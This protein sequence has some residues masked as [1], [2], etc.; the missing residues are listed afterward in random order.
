MLL[1]KSTLDLF[2][3]QKAMLLDVW[4]SK[5][6]QTLSQETKSRPKTLAPF[7]YSENFTVKT[8]SKQPFKPVPSPFG[9]GNHEQATQDAFV[10]YVGGRSKAEHL[11][12]L[13][14]HSYPT[15]WPPDHRYAKTKAEVFRNKAKGE[16]FSDEDVDAFMQLW[17]VERKHVQI[18]WTY[19]CQWDI[20]LAY[21]FI[22][23]TRGEVVW[24]GG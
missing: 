17:N 16:G 9:T 10:E 15:P 24:R 8:M 2:R 13:W 22:D 14:Q 5:G 11:S 21:S 20:S 23:R 1:S 19:E 7:V 18:L 12:R 4:L 3:K 6:Y